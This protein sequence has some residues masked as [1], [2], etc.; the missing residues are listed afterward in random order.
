MGIYLFADKKEGVST[1]ALYNASFNESMTQE[2]Y[3][4]YLSKKAELDGL[5]DAWYEFFYADKSN[6]DLRAINS[7]EVFGYGKYKKPIPSHRNDD[8]W[9]EPCGGESDSNNIEL[10]CAL[11]DINYDGIKDLIDVLH[12]S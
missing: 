5:D 1:L 12:W 4:Y 11:N 6:A 8:G 2:R 9:L 10:M 7:F 3:E